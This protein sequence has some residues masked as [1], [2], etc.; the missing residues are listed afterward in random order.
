MLLVICSSSNVC[1]SSTLPT[2]N[3]R[4]PISQLFATWRDIKES[5]IQM[6]IVICSSVIAAYRSIAVDELQ[7]QVSIYMQRYTS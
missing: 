6:P 4:W 3:K 1:H 2:L 7:A 5:V